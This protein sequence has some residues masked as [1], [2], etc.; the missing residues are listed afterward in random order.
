MPCGFIQL[1]V[2]QEAIAHR[3]AYAT[4][5]HHRSG[6]AG[7][8][9]GIQGI[10][11]A[12]HIE[13]G[14]NQALVIGLLHQLQAF[15]RLLI[16][17]APDIFARIVLVDTLIL[18][19]GRADE[20]IGQ[21]A[22][23]ARQG[24][25]IGAHVAG[26]LFLHQA[27]IFH[28]FTGRIGILDLKANRIGPVFAQVDGLV[29]HHHVAGI[30]VVHDHAEERIGAAGLFFQGLR[31]GH[32]ALGIGN[33]GPA[34]LPII[35]QAV[36]QPLIDVGVDLVDVK[37]IPAQHVGHIAGVNHRADLIVGIAVRD[38]QDVKVVV[39]VLGKPL[40]ADA[41]LVVVRGG[42]QH[43]AGDLNGQVLVVGLAAGVQGI[44]VLLGTGNVLLLINHVFLVRCQGGCAAQQHQDA[45]EQCH[46]FLGFHGVTS[47]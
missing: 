47:L 42:V 35:G 41:A 32:Q 1:E 40:A 17:E 37:T 28:D 46:E 31:N 38:G 7:N 45:Q 36:E 20:Q 30:I 11:F 19:I 9:E 13:F 24:N 26:I 44:G 12:V 33:V 43:F 4:G 39:E 23:V 10:A 22:G 14:A 25:Q 29:I 16:G 18:R 34:L 3:A 2:V 5:V 21:I 8:A 27:R 15:Q 6:H